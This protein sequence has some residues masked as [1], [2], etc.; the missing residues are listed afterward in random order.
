MAAHA[1]TVADLNLDFTCRYA[2]SL[3]IRRM[4]RIADESDHERD[5]F[6]PCER[7]NHPCALG[8]KADTDQQ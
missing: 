6:N 3:V 2:D 5:E 1:I 8:G 7:Q 4:P